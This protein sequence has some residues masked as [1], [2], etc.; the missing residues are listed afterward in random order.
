MAGFGVR[1]EMVVGVSF[2][3]VP[4]VYFPLA[5]EASDHTRSMNLD[6]NPHGWMQGYF[7]RPYSIVVGQ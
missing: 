7:P 2:R 6:L 4:V 1:G 3:F 5:L